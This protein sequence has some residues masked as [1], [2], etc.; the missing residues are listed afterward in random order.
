MLLCC[1]V[2]ILVENMK[3][4]EVKEGAVLEVFVKPRSKEFKI[5]VENGEIVI[6]CREE[7]VKG[8]ANKEII[9]ELSRLFGKKVEL[10]SGFSSRQKRLLVKDI[11][12]SE[13][14]GILRRCAK[15][16]AE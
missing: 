3:I 10:V 12:R 1:E 9:K 13:A 6:F 2:D 15:T 8:K 14:E 5:A 7:P 16:I 4:G 11:K